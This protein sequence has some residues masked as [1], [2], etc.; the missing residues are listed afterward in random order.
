[1]CLGL[2][3]LTSLMLAMPEPPAGLAAGFAVSWWIALAASAVT[4][5]CV[6]ARRSLLVGFALGAGTSLAEIAFTGAPS[7]LV[8]SAILGVAL[9]GSTAGARFG[10]ALRRSTRLHP[11]PARR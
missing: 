6:F 5:G 11:S 8:T 10:A 9:V 3:G 7:S 4:F 2:C 1:M